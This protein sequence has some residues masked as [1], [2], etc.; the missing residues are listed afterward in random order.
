MA[1]VLFVIMPLMILT[2]LAMSPAMMRSLPFLP[3]M[4]GG[5]QTARTIHF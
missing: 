2:G 1:V 3:D 5:R 4:L